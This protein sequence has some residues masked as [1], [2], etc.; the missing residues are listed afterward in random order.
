MSD[1]K[2]PDL[3][4]ALTYRDVVEIL[5]LVNES[6]NCASLELELGNLKLSATRAGTHSEPAAVP[7]QSA[8][9]AAAP[10][11]AAGVCGE[12]ANHAGLAAVRAPML[13]T[14]YH[15]PA[16][17]EPPYVVPGDLVREDDTIGL[18]DVMKLFTQIPAGVA[19]RVVEVVAQNGALVEY[20]Q[21][22]VLI[23]PL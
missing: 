1:R 10:L 6:S 7:G 17:G 19:G 11:E 8:P 9:A 22:L 14:F 18:I 4:Y 23:E 3:S 13:G 15:A 21:V 12:A 2:E 20:G 16:P 5:R